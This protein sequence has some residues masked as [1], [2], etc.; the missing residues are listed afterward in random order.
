MG[1][2]SVAFIHPF[3]INCND[4]ALATKFAGGIIY[5]FWVLDRGSV[6]LEGPAD[7]IRDN[8]NL[9]RLLAP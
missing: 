4:Y 1:K 3:S 7:E 5:E 2:Y 9:L 6:A 8:P